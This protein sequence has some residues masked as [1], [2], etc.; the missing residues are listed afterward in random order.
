[1]VVVE[2]HSLLEESHFPFVKIPHLIKIEYH[3][4]STLNED[5]YIKMPSMTSSMAK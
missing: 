1:M 3:S 2:L 5:G 4:I